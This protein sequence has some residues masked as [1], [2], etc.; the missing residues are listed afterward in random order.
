MIYIYI[1]IYWLGDH[2]NVCMIMITNAPPPLH[3]LAAHSRSHSQ[4][5]LELS[6]SK[7]L[8]RSS[9]GSLFAELIGDFAPYKSFLQLNNR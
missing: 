2:G 3:A 4:E 8:T 9:D 1:Y 5:W 7:Q 6:P